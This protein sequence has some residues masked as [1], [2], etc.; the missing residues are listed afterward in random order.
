MWENDISTT[1]KHI[2][3]YK[4]RMV[5]HTSQRSHTNKEERLETVEGK[6]FDL[7]FI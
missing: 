1:Y 6:E 7:H 3:I 2:E 5:I 4:T